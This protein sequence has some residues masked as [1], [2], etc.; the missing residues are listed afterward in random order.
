[1]INNK[2]PT[3]KPSLNLDFA[4]TKSLDPRITFRRGTPGTYY[5][6]VTH[7]KAEENLIDYS[8]DFSQWGTY[9]LSVT[10]NSTTAPDGSTTADKI[11]DSTVDGAHALYQQENYT[12][13]TY[14]FSS[15]F[16]SS[17][18]NRYIA[19][20]LYNAAGYYIYIVFDPATG[21]VTHSEN[22]GQSRI[23][24][25]S[26]SSVSYANDWYRGIVMFNVSEDYSIT[27]GWQITDSPV[28]NASSSP[29]Q[30]AF[31]GDGSS[32]FYLWG[33]QLE[34][35]D[36]VTSYT[37]TTGAPITKYQPKLMTASPDDARFDHDPITGESKGLLI[38]EQRTNLIE[39]SEDFA[40]DYWTHPRADV[41]A[42]AIAPDGTS[43]AV[44]LVANVSHSGGM[45]VYNLVNAWSLAAGSTTTHSCYFKKGDNDYAAIWVSNGAGSGANQYFDILNGT[46]ESGTTYGSVSFTI[47]DASIQNVGNG[48]FRC[49]LTI[50]TDATSA[51][52]QFAPSL[53]TGDGSNLSCTIYETRGFLWGAQVEA[54]SFATS[55]IKT[56]GASATR[57]ADNAS[58]TGENFSSWYRQD[59]GTIYLSSEVHESRTAST[60]EM[61]NF[62]KDSSNY[63]A[64]SNTGRELI[65]SLYTNGSTQTQLYNQ[66]KSQTPYTINSSVGYKKDSASLFNKGEQ[67]MS[68]DTSAEVASGLDK[69]FIGNRNN[70]FWTGKLYI[71]KLAYYPQRLTNEQLENLTK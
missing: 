40:D 61:L 68:E 63:I 29:H 15:F 16:K 65:S 19:F 11:S 39:Y 67:V 27:T 35:R 28:V 24:L 62:Y 20:R 7:A 51:R 50:T 31:A 64:I 18:D 71:K 17:G 57:S 66:L 3:T 46:V 47:D 4:N 56:T 43:S 49:S 8:E 60:Y 21:S 30:S 45:S 5:D 36:T 55:Y 70:S 9:E 26:A 25:I 41:Y 58:I 6:G 38:E 22:G 54:G 33:A 13:G 2:Y 10:S 42:N 52:S 44:E 14:I 23:A 37:A 48:W 12:R 34:Q 32:G 1:M 69:L 53:P 59:E